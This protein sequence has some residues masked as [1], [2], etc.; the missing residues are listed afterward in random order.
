MAK[1]INLVSQTAH[2]LFQWRGISKSDTRHSETG[3][4]EG[5]RLARMP[6]LRGA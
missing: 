5:G 3:P 6:A 1:C 2:L 4:P